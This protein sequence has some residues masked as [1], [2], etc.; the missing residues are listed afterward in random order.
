MNRTRPKLPSP[1]TSGA[2]AASMLL[3]QPNGSTAKVTRDALPGRRWS[4]VYAGVNQA[5]G[6]ALVVSGG[7]LPRLALHGGQT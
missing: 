2:Q 4:N 5:A 1:E 6:S 7:E 3:V